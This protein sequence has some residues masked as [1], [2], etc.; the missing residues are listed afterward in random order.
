MQN[1]SL[2]KA[3]DFLQAHCQRVTAVEEVPLLSAW[4]RILAEDYIA[5]FA[6]PPFDRSPLDGYTFAAEETVRIIPPSLRL[7]VRKVRAIFLPK[8][9]QRA[10]PCAL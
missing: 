4:G 1:L 3:V 2:E 9:C 10:V 7:S 6:N 8:K 5:P